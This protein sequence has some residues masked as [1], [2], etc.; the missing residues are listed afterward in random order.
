MAMAQDSSDPTGVAKVNDVNTSKELVRARERKAN[1]ALDMA[2]H[3]ANWE[4]IAEVLGFPT[5]R[6]AKVAV[7]GA[8][9]R[10]LDTVDRQKLRL[11]VHGRLNAALASISPKAMDPEHAEHIAALGRFREIVADQ[12]RMWGLDAPQE[13]LVTNPTQREIDDWV[14][15]AV[16][17][18]MP[19]VEE[20]DIVDGEV[21]EDFHNPEA[22]AS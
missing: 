15:V 12:R 2:L 3:G 17:K 21:V 6:T 13:V 14:G 7:E 8:L 4:Q 16:S 9:E 22:E 1:A 18:G 19:T 20:D 10:N 11:M 5:A